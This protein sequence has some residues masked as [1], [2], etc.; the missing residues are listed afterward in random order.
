MRVGCV[1]QQRSC[2]SAEGLFELEQWLLLEPGTDGVEL[3]GELA[4]KAVDGI[5]YLYSAS[6]RN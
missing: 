6:V 1:V 2:V 3:A 4:G 5:W